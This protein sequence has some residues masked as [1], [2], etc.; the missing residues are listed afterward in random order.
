VAADK[1]GIKMR[2]QIY[3]VLDKM[4]NLGANG[5]ELKELENELLTAVIPFSVRGDL[6]KEI[7]EFSEQNSEPILKK[8]KR[9]A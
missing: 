7:R 4:R 8:V 6:L 3:D 2:K 5:K 1:R 9:D